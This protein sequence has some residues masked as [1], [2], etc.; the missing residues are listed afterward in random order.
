[1]ENWDSGLCFAPQLPRGFDHFYGAG[2]GGE[3]PFPAGQGVH[4]RYPVSTQGA[5]GEGQMQKLL[6]TKTHKRSLY[7]SRHNATIF[8][9]LGMRVKFQR[10][11]FLLALPDDFRCP[12]CAAPYSAF[13]A[14]F[15]FE[16]EIC[17]D[18]SN[19]RTSNRFQQLHAKSMRCIFW[20][21]QYQ[22]ICTKI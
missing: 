13:N 22:R 10:L 21:C 5:V 4:P 7:E 18:V 3:P 19:Q 17:I 9:H 12:L 16:W 15:R 2:R 6:R 20:Y 14:W 1:M 8:F 11:F